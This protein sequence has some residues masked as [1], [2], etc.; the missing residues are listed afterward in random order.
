MG[1]PSLASAV[2]LPEAS[3][4][5]P[6]QSAGTKRTQPEHLEQGDASSAKRQRTSDTLAENA[7]SH[8]EAKAV[9]PAVH[10]DRGHKTSAASKSTVDETKDKRRNQR[11]FGALLGGLGGGGAAASRAPR[12]SAVAKRRQEQEERRKDEAR[13]REAE[14]AERQQERLKKLNE[15]RKIQQRRVYERDLRVQHSNMRARANYLQTEAE[16]RVYYEPWKLRPEEEETIK[17][18][19]EDVEIQIDKDLDDLADLRRKWRQEDG[20]DA[21]DILDNTRHPSPEPNDEA[22]R[23]EKGAKDEGAEDRAQRDEV[24][25]EKEPDENPTEAIVSVQG[26]AQRKADAAESGKRELEEQREEE[27][28]RARKSSVDEADDVVVEGEEDTVIY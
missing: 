20:E 23:P 12:D 27:L 10:P 14:L 13:K 5:P 25:Q 16:P 15:E 24:G 8:D 18:Q 7:T 4:S 6:P 21:E 1:Q 2:V 3:P 11:L 19:K 28:R 22:P 17:R 26:D 9:P